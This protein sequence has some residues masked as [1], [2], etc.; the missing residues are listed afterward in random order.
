MPHPGRA[1]TLSWSRART[2]AGRPRP[3]T[4]YAAKMGLGDSFIIWCI[5]DMCRLRRKGRCS[6]WAATPEVGLKSCRVGLLHDFTTRLCS[7]RLRCGTE[8]RF[9]CT[10]VSI[11]LEGYSCSNARATPA[12]SPH[13]RPHRFVPA[14][15]FGLPRA[16]PQSQHTSSCKNTCGGMSVCGSREERTAARS[17]RLSSAHASCVDSE[18]NPS[19]QWALDGAAANGQHDDGNTRCVVVLGAPGLECR[20]AAGRG[21][22]S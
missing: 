19:S 14:Q 9:R 21:H 22:P 18:T 16:S 2:S 6:W 20:A 11:D 3:S 10:A 7:P 1:G 4:S 15:S 8:A 5:H 13:A 17:V 12:L